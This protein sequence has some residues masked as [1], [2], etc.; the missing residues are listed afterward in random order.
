MCY[1][2][3][4]SRYIIRVRTCGFAVKRDLYAQARSARQLVDTTQR[5]VSTHK[6][7]A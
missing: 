3:V 4:L 7:L 5:F 2:D 1:E 6:L